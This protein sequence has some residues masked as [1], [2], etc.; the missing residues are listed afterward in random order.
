MTKLSVIMPVYN[1]R[2]TILEIIG[3]IKKARLGNTEKEIVIVDDFSTDGT[4][5]ILKKIKEKGIKILYHHKNMGKGYAIRT[6]LKNITGDIV[7]IQDADLEY[8]PQEYGKLIEPIIR[9]ESAVVYGS[10]NLVKNEYSTLSFFLGGKAVT[11]IANLLYNTKI[12][13]EP[14]C[15]KVFKSEIFK[16]INL[17]CK[18]FEFCPEITAK[19]SK[20]GYKIKEIPISY[21]P[22]DKK[23]GKKIK[24]RDGI[25]AVWTLIKYRFKD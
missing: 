14:T 17:K 16:K 25:E 19:V 24:W 11:V 18:R 22:R 3:E 9:G 2:E 7:I 12:T 1:E 4:R 13:D 6:A 10:R 8:D 21:H 15:Y 20:L 5:E 23:Q